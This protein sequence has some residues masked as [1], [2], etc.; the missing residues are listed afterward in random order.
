MD[1]AP[2]LAKHPV[3]HQLVRQRERHHEEA[4]KHVSHGQRGDEPVLDALEVVLCRDGDHDEHVAYDY[5]DDHRR[6]DDGQGHDLEDCVVEG[7]LKN[8]GHVGRKQS[9][10]VVVANVTHVRVR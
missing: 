8:D 1:L 5:D 4:Q 10:V 9:G 7:A 3:R 6:H 2:D